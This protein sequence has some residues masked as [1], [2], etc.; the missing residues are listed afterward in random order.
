M[1]HRW[2][3]FISVLAL[4]L[5]VLITSTSAWGAP[6]AAGVMTGYYTLWGYEGIGTVGGAVGG[7]SPAQ[8]PPIAD[9]GSTHCRYIDLSPI[10]L[11][12]YYLRYPLHL[13]NGANITQVSL[14][15]ADF[16]STGNLY[17][18]LRSRP[19]N[20]RIGN[21]PTLASTSSTANGDQTLNMTGLN[22]NVDNQLKQYWVDVAPDNSVVPYADHGSLCVYGVQVTYTIDG[23]LLPLIQRGF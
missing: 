22:V 3:L 18:S 11:G 8:T 5:V 1:N 16:A 15:V 7:P 13:P 12:Y 14:F 21:D 10:T 19:W 23:A 6:A 2:Y 20:S 17:V 4:L 9:Y